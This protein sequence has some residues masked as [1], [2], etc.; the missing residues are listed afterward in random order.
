MNSIFRKIFA[1]NGKHRSSPSLSHHPV[2]S[3]CLVPFSKLYFLCRLYHSPHAPLCFARIIPHTF[4]SF[5]FKSF[6][7]HILLLFLHYPSHTTVF[8]LYDSRH[9]PLCF[10]RTIRHIFYSVLFVR[11][12]THSN[13]FNL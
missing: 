1:Q 5:S 9:T 4:H 10:G 12:S 2:S 13:L 6:S 11:F 8:Y 7:T 3:P